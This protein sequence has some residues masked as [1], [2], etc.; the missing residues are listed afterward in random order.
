LPLMVT[1][2][3]NGQ[4][5]FVSSCLSVSV[6]FVQHS[7]VDVYSVSSPLVVFVPC[8]VYRRCILLSLMSLHPSTATVLYQTCSSLPHGISY[9]FCFVSTLVS[10]RV[11]A[12]Q[13]GRLS[14]LFDVLSS[15]SVSSDVL[16][17]VLPSYFP[18]RPNDFITSP[19]RPNMKM[20]QMKP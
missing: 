15:C 13:V 19:I 6:L 4:P 9:R 5:V 16:S 20:T 17:C 2:T 1:R 7:E 14:Y 18:H 11:S 8:V 10:S 12:C 3:L